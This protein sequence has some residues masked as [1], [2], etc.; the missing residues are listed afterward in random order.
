MRKALHELSHIC[1]GCGQLRM[2]GVCEQC[3]EEI[4][5][6]NNAINDALDGFD[7]Y[8]LGY[9]VSPNQ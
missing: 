2:L 6:E 8:A 5:R 4:R 3:R 1:E 9:Y 7:S